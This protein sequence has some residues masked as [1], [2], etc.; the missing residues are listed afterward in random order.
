MTL[1]EIVKDEGMYK[2]RPLGKVKYETVCE[3]YSQAAIY[4]QRKHGKL[5]RV[6]N[7]P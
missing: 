1:Y 3:Y 2:V 7:R 4:I 5:A 6:V